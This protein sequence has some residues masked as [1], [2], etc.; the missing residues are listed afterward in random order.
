[1]DD[2][3]ESHLAALDVGGEEDGVAGMAGDLSLER[4]LQAEIS[5]GVGV[6]VALVI[7]GVESGRRAASDAGV[8]AVE[9]LRLRV[10]LHLSKP[11]SPSPYAPSYLPPPLSWIDAYSNSCFDLICLDLSCF[12]LILIWEEEERR[13]NQLYVQFFG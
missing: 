3:G 8:D 13:T 11:L 7:G 2:G 1:M 10:H 5:V 9:I 6:G 4:L 12:A